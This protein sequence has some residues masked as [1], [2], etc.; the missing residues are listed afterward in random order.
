MFCSMKKNIKIFTQPKNSTL[1]YLARYPKF[2]G[3]GGTPPQPI[4]KRIK[5]T[6]LNTHNLLVFSLSLKLVHK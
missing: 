3:M 5:D 4:Q 1:N 6:A 2:T